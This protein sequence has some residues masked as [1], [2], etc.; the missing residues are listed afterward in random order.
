MIYILRFLPVVE[1]DAIV[2]FGGVYSG[3]FHMPSTFG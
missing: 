1:E 3:D 2:N